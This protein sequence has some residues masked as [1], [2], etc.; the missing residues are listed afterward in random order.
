MKKFTRIEPT[1]VQK[2]SER[3]N[4]VV[5]TK[6]FQT[7]DGLQHEFAT[8]GHEETRCGAVIAL[9]SDG[10]VVTTYEFRAGPERWMYELPG[11]HIE[12]GEDPQVGALRELREETGYIPG[13]VEFLGESIRDAY[14][15]GTWYYYLATDCTLSAEGAQ[16]D[17]VEQDQGVE[18][19][20]ISITELIE[21]ARTGYMT[22]PVAVLMAYD[23]LKEIAKENQS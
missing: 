6:R 1:T 3:F 7:E 17:E 14:V 2:V 22:D 13:R 18:A 16:Q 5:V 19:H 15:N 10:Q 23:K 11:G 21:N 12:K 4:R 20:L 8:W 9:T